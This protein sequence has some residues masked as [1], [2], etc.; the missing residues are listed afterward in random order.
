MVNSTVVPFLN[1]FSNLNLSNVS[2]FNSSIRQAVNQGHHLKALLLFRQ[3]KQNG[4][5]PN[6]FTFPF[7]AKAC[8]NL[9]NARHSLFVHAHTIKSPY[10]SDVYVR[11]ALIDMYVKCDQL[12]YALALFEEMPKRDVTAWN[13]II[14]GFM[15]VGYFDRVAYLFNRMKFDGVRPDSVSVM[16]LTQLTSSVKDVM[17]LSSVHGLGIKTGLEFNVSVANT[18]IAAYAKC[19]NPAA[20]EM[21]FDGIDLC[22]LTVVSWNS[23]IS[24]CA[25]A[26]EGCKAMEIYQRMLVSGFSPDLGTILN[27]LGSFVKPEALYQGKLIHCHGIHLGCNSDISVLNTLIYMYSRCAEISSSRSVF[28]SMMDRTCVSWTAMI[29]GYAERGDL[30][31]AIALFHE[32]EVVGEKPD[33]VTVMHVISACGLVGALEMGRWIDEYALSRGF[34]S[35]ATIC[36]TL[37]DMYAKCGSIIDAE[38]LF[39][40]MSERTVVSWT[41]MIAGYALNGKSREALNYFKLMLK[42]GLKPNRITF[43]SVLQA[44]VHAGLLEEGQECFDT[45]T[46]VYKINASLDH[47]SC[48][49]DLL[50]R[51]GKVKEALHYVQ[52]MPVEPD[53][54]IWAALLCACKNHRNV[55]IGEY[56][57]YRLFQVEPHAAAPYVEMANIYASAGRWE[58]VALVRTKMKS[59]QVSKYPG[60]SIIQVNGKS[61]TFR[62]EDRS[63]P[64]GFLIFKLLNILAL[65]FKDEFDF[66]LYSMVLVS[67]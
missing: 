41:T 33:L 43:L 49:A 42:S 55:D 7:V 18:W 66:S 3:M 46:K 6:N 56:A 9:S 14:V 26:G 52:N 28:D 25:Y 65:H 36:N 5:E 60:E 29:A 13:A 30:D 2:F 27:L 8:A 39:S 17:L 38:Q 19:G 20:A 15:E 47:Y 53:A 11:T 1:R 40:T 59:N 44:C 22:Y 37:L 24:G 21:V 32:M 63:H 57:A 62:V 23:M 10:N 4:L 50:G 16:W 45:M 12:D 34:K 35:D 48:M 54:G 31:K 67:E 61:Y 58:G 64:E 51:R